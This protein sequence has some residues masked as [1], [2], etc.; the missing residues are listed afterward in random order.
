MARLLVIIHGFSGRRCNKRG[1]DLVRKFAEIWG[2]NTQ[3]KGWVV[4]APHFDEKRFNNDYQRLSFSGTR[5]DLRLNQLVEET[6]RIMPRLPTDRFFLFGFSGGGQFVHRYVA[7]HPERIERAVA[8]SPGW[9][10]W[11]DLSIPYPIGAIVNSSPNES[12]RRLL[13]LCQQ[14]LLILVGED[15]T[16]QGAFRKHFSDFDLCAL[17][18]KGRRERAENWFSELRQFAIQERSAF[19]V[20]LKI[21]SR[22][23]HKL[24]N[25]FIQCAKAYLS[26]CT[27]HEP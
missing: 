9:Y 15:D 5:A 22:T 18:G 24:N 3:D 6:A 8:G 27:S 23:R 12:H 21:L 26:Q 7:F 10:M 1:R 4:L 17:Q 14:D 25:R 19:R 11:P 20:R 13:M 2:Q 16:K